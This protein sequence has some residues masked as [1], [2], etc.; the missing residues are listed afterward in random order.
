MPTESPALIPKEPST[1]KEQTPQAMLTAALAVYAGVLFVDPAIKGAV[2][3]STPFVSMAV[4]W[5]LRAG[6]KEWR[7]WRESTKVRRGFDDYLATIDKRLRSLPLGAAERAELEADAVAVRRMRH[8]SIM[9]QLVAYS[10]PTPATPPAPVAVT[11]ALQPLL[12]T[13]PAP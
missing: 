8:E 1:V 2:V 3:A 5:L 11:A 4:F 10:Q 13:P 7:A 12:P 6:A 9:R